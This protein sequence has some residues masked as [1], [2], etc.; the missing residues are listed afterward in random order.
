MNLHLQAASAAP[1]PRYAL[2]FVC[3]AD[4]SRSYDF[5]CDEAG[6]VDLDTLSERARLNYFYARTLIGREVSLPAVR[7]LH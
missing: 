3:L 7:V 1:T 6:R 5:E 4:A 2:R